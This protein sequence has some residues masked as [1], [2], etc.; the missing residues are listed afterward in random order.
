LWLAPN[1]L[2]QDFAHF[3][4]SAPTVLSR[5]LSELQLH[6]VFEV[7]NHHLSHDKCLQLRYHDIATSTAS[8][9]PFSR[10][11]WHARPSAFWPRTCHVA[12]SLPEIQVLA[13][14]THDGSE[15]VAHRLAQIIPFSHADDC[16]GYEDGNDAATLRRAIRCSSWGPQNPAETGRLRA[17]RVRGGPAR[18]RAISLAQGKRVSRA[19]RTTFPTVLRSKK[20]QPLGSGGR[21]SSSCENELV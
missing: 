17:K 13:R 1:G 20:P 19:W 10:F 8:V 11:A 4:L 5:T 16:A 7:A 15:K 2:A 3:L 12:C 9:S 21:S 6:I 18:A 14:L